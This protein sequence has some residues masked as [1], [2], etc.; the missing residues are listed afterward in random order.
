[1]KWFSFLFLLI[2]NCLQSNLF[3]QENSE[4]E[5]AEKIQSLEIA[6]ISRK[7][8]LNPEE[9][10]RFWPVYNDYKKEIRQIAKDQ[11]QR[12]EQD[13]IEFEQKLID[14]RK[15]YRDQFSG[16]VGK[17]RMNQF[18]KAEHEFRGILLNR[19]KNHAGRQDNIP[20]NKEKRFRH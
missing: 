19:I 8:D 13:V 16:V 12:Q 9:A 2:A 6:F 15:K 14:V 20:L 18:F 11:K 3:A 1:M 4:K 7:L 5:R 10:Q 17:E